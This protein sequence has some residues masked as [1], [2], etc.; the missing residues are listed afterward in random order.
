MIDAAQI[1]ADSITDTS[2]SQPIEVERRAE[3]GGSGGYEGGK[4]GTLRGCTARVGKVAAE[5]QA[6]AK[7]L[8][9]KLRGIDEDG[10]LSSSGKASRKAEA[11]EAHDKAAE[12][13]LARVES[14]NARDLTAYRAGNSK[15]IAAAGGKPATELSLVERHSSVQTV[16][17]ALSGTS[18]AEFAAAIGRHLGESPGYSAELF[19][20]ACLRLQATDAGEVLVLAS[21]VR[22]SAR[23]RQRRLV[24]EA[25]GVRGAVARLALAHECERDLKTTLG[26]A[27]VDPEALAARRK[28]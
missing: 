13:K 6:D 11:T 25:P 20:A 2:L 12:A 26:L 18:P 19:D 21:Q 3:Y 4:Q 9:S 17:L 14:E 1:V 27:R 5:I 10:D 8:A 16:L 7:V 22:G 15:E 24:L 23:E 28:K